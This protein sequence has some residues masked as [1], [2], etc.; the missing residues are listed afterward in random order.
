MVSWVYN[1]IAGGHL[2]VANA[3]RLRV[4]LVLHQRDPSE[5]VRDQPLPVQHVAWGL[6]LARRG[7]EGASVHPG[8]GHA[9]RPPALRARPQ[10]CDRHHRLCRR[11]GLSGQPL[12]GAADLEADLQG[13]RRPRVQ[14]VRLGAGHHVPVD[15]R[16]ALCR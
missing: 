14:A 15:S 11:V 3:D 10:P 16:G 9:D 4:R 1:G 2:R 6:Q 13:Q 8:H 7:E 5:R 12:P